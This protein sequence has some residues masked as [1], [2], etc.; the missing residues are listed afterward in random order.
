MKRFEMVFPLVLVPRGMQEQT[1]VRFLK[2]TR[3]VDKET[4]LIVGDVSMLFIL[5]FFLFTLVSGPACA[6]HN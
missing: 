5:L 4:V 3:R 2:K 6:H 1:W